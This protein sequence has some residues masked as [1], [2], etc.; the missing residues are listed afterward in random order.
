MSIAS[1]LGGGIMSVVSGIMGMALIGM[2][3]SRS[4]DVTNIAGELTKDLT[5][6]IKAASF[7]N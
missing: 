2:L 5:D 7:S 1:D 4:S 3:L 6:L